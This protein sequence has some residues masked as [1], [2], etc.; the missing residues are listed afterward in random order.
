MFGTLREIQTVLR[1]VSGTSLYR[2]TQIAREFERLSASSY[3]RPSQFCREVLAL[4]EMVGELKPQGWINPRPAQLISAM[5]SGGLALLLEKPEGTVSILPYGTVPEAFDFILMDGSF[6]LLA[7]HRTVLGG[8]LIDCAETENSSHQPISDSS[9]RHQKELARKMIQT[10]QDSSAWN[11]LCR[12]MKVEERLIQE[13]VSSLLK[14]NASDGAFP[15]PPEQSAEALVRLLTACGPDKMKTRRLA[16]F[17]QGQDWAVKSHFTR[18]TFSEI[19]SMA[20][21]TESVYATLG[22]S[23]IMPLA[24]QLGRMAGAGDESGLDEL[25]TTQKI[26]GTDCRL[27]VRQ[28][29]SECLGGLDFVLLAEGRTVATLGCKMTE[30]ELIVVRIQGGPSYRMFQENIAA[31]ASL[32]DFFGNDPIDWL[33]KNLNVWGRAAGFD[34][35]KAFG[36]ELNKTVTKQIDEGGFDEGRIRHA[37]LQYDARIKRNWGLK[38]IPD[39]RPIFTTTRHLKPLLLEEISANERVIYDAMTEALS[40]KPRARLF[41]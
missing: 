33:F 2:Q 1:D 23:M 32:K 5:G 8:M 38:P 3:V 36:Y 28:G 30:R 39:G 40:R 41:F 14:S 27:E 37:K 7:G 17:L 31:E 4:G 21:R 9:Y 26:P 29:I 24:I 13:A 16:G 6:A 12:E 25:V 15:E 19:V 18:Q 34:R 20:L 10:P 35:I 11:D 22:L